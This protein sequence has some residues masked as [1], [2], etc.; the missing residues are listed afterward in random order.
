MLFAVLQAK[1]PPETSPVA[2]GGPDEV[3]QMYGPP[4]DWRSEVSQMYGPPSE[5]KGKVE[6]EESLRQ[7]IRPVGGELSPGHDEIR[8]VPVLQN[9]SA[10]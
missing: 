8:R 7:C 10:L 5:C 1:G 4:P 3:S 2:A 6:G 9:A